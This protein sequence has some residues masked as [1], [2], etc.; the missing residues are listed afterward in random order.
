MK[1][2]KIHIFDLCI[3][4]NLLK[5]KKDTPIDLKHFLIIYS[6]KE[7]Y[8]EEYQKWNSLAI[9]QFIVKHFT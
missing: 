3:L 1:T 8:K 2:F 4:L 7:T 5:P 9:G 6:A